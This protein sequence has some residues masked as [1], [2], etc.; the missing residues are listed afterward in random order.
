MKW[1]GV[2]EFRINKSSFT[3]LELKIRGGGTKKSEESETD[4]MNIVSETLLNIYVKQ[5]HFNKA[6]LGYE[7]LS[8]QNPDKSAYFAA[9]I[10]EIKQTQNES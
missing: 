1:W 4:K 2:G 8:L 7:K 6:I 9:R 5:G 3:A 10:K